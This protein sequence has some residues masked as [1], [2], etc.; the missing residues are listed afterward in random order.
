MLVIPG[1]RPWWSSGYHTRL[2]IQG[3]ILAGIYGFFS[4]RK[5]PEYDILRKGS[6][7][8]GTEL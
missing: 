4:E 1:G 7:A 6:K 8:M 5:N 2:W 3:S